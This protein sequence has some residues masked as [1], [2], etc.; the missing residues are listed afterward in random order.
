MP[1]TLL[2]CNVQNA[3]NYYEQSPQTP[4][5]TLTP[6]VELVKLLGQAC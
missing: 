4:E 6:R 1:H 5:D 2:Q 3:M